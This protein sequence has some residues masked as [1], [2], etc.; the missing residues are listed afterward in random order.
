[1]FNPFVCQVRRKGAQIVFV[2]EHLGCY[3]GSG[4]TTAQPTPPQSTHSALL[5]LLI[6]PTSLKHNLCNIHNYGAV[7]TRPC[8]SGMDATQ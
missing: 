2:L 8:A 7:A 4:P 6:L 1:M 5:P 3:R